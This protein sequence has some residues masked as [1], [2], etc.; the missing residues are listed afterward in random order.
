M[1]D[2]KSILTEDYGYTPYEAELTIED[3]QKMDEESKKAL[4]LYLSGEDV[5]AYGFREYTVKTLMSNYSMNEIAA[6]LAISELK[7]DY[8]GFSEILK[9]GI[10]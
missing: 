6:L 4:E 7:R 10:K 9:M 5:I 8:D 1:R 3:I 2:Y